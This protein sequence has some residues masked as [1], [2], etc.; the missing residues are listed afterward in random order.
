MADIFDVKMP[1]NALTASKLSRL[2]WA[3]TTAVIG[4]PIMGQ[5][6]GAMILFQTEVPF[7][8]SGTAISAFC[9]ATMFVLL[10]G[11]YVLINRVHLRFSGLNRGLDEWESD[12]KGRAQAFSYKV[13]F[14]GLFV[15]FIVASVLGLLGFL[16]KLNWTELT[17]GQSFQ[18]NLS[19]ISALV[20]GLFYL[21]FFLPTLYMAWTL[22]PLSEK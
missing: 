10:A 15:A 16:N 18:L 3:T 11:I 21:I 5:I 6:L 2:K 20:I 8:T 17:F 4:I 13:I 19:G 9:F 12:I 7:V 14:W 1:L 22:K